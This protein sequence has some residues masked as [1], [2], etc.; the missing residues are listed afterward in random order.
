MAAQLT[1]NHRMMRCVCFFVNITG[2]DFL[3]GARFAGN[4]YAG[5]WRVRSDRP[6]VMTLAMAAEEK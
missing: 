1:G 3:A 6:S 5:V 4:Q 2:D